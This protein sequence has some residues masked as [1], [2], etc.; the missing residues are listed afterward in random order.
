MGTGQRAS[1]REQ[2]RAAE[3]PG[4]GAYNPRTQDTLGRQLL[5]TRRSSATVRFGTSTRDQAARVAISKEHDKGGAGRD[6]PG[7][8]TAGQNKGVGAQ[9]STVVCVCVCAF[10]CVC[11]LCVFVCVLGVEVIIDR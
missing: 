10:V 7:P 2:R 1:A 9:V 11:V 3:I 8:G 5:S 4:A 6:S